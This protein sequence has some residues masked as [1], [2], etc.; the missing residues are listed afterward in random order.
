MKK[1]LVSLLV[2]TSLFA[3]TKE[4]PK[5]P[6]KVK[7]FKQNFVLTT[8][9]GK[10]LHITVTERGLKVK[11]Y[12][13]R[14]IIV[15][16]FGKNCPP[17][18]MEMPILGEL[19]KKKKDRL[20]IIGLHVQ[21]PLSKADIEDLKRRGINYPV[22]DYLTDKQNGAFVE[23]MAQA[24]RWSGSIPYML[25]FKKNG[26]YAGYHLGIASPQGLEKLVD[27]LYEEPKKQ[28]STKPKK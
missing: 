16:F 17:C 23:Y 19:Q 5:E 4:Q 13:N 2:I 6:K 22:A 28:V 1:L 24:T 7:E 27:R 12:P 26:D 25:F 14:V 21:Q 11:E 10:K 8:T 20:Q 15:D 18:R 9:D 3:V